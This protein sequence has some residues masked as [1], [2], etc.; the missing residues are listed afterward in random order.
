M[1]V[2]K[3][4]TLDG[5]LRKDAVIDKIILFCLINNMYD[6]NVEKTSFTFMLM[7]GFEFEC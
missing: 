7:F 4:R 1:E 2:K 3:E 5:E 6:V